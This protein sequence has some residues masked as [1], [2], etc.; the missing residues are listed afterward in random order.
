MTLQQHPELA[1]LA[2]STAYSGFR[3]TCGDVSSCSTLSDVMI[4]TRRCLWPRSFARDR[5][6]VRWG[7]GLGGRQEWISSSSSVWWHQAGR[8]NH[9]SPGALLQSGQDKEQY[10][11]LSKVH[12]PGSAEIRSVQNIVVMSSFAVDRIEQ[13]RKARGG[14]VGRFWMEIFDQRLRRYWGSAKASERYRASK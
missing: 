6:E 10:A 5:G 11:L 9:S 2:T 7:A 4:F 1:Y 13:S 12:A 14:G 3:S 8:P